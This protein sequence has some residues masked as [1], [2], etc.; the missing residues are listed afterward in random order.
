MVVITD[1]QD[2]RPME[3]AKK[4]REEGVIIFAVGVGN[5]RVGSTLQAIAGDT[6]YQFDA[7]DF[8]ELDGE[9]SAVLRRSLSS[10]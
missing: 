10:W 9:P 4:A 5:G 6:G 3:E 8:S 2:S 7:T 1:G